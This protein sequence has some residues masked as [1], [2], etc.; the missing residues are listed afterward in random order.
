[1]NPLAIAKEFEARTGIKVGV[2]TLLVGSI[3]TNCLL[4]AGFFTIDRTHRETLVPPTINKTFWV[5][6][7]QVSDSYMEQMGLFI[8]RN[9]LDVT[10][11]SA[12][13]QARMIL[14]YAAPASYGELERE[15]ITTAKR[16]QKDGVSTFYSVTSVTPDGK[17]RQVVFNGVLRTML[18]DKV[19]SDVQKQYAIKF[20]QSNGRVF[21]KELREINEKVTPGADGGA[22]AK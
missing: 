15:L 12:E 21:V 16:Q 14:K 4:A 2:Q 8:L 5:E 11:V 17:N 22:V 10:P 3:L 18:G 20:G 1:M 13:Y 6:D 19:V 7:D 9:A